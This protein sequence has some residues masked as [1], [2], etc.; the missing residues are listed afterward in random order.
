MEMQATRWAKRQVEM[1]SSSCRGSLLMAASMTVAQLPP[2]L[3]F[4]IAV[5]IELR[6]GTWWRTCSPALCSCQPPAPSP[7]GGV[8]AGNDHATRTVLMHLCLQ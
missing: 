2:R 7:T 3:S 4:S 8:R 1:D 5:S 6:Y